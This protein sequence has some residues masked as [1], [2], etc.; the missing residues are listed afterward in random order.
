[1]VLG[2]H[3]NGSLYLPLHV[4]VMLSLQVLDLLAPRLSVEG[5]LWWT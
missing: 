1:M 3:L 4:G 2:K 5:R